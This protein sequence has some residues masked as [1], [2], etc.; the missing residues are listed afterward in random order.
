MR[1]VVGLLAGMMW[2]VASLWCLSKLLGAWLGP[3]SSRRR[4]V[5]WLMVK[6]PL[7][8]AMTFLLLRSPAMSMVGFGVGFSVVLVGAIA[9]LVRRTP[10]VMVARAHGR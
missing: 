1:F 2:N 8:Y 6:F 4:V 10:R 3:N 7:L 9:W 5:M